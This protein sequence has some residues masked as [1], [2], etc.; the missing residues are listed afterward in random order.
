[1]TEKQW[2]LPITVEK[3]PE[4]GLPV[5]KAGRM[6][7]SEPFFYPKPSKRNPKLRLYT[8]VMYAALPTRAPHN[9]SHKDV[10]GQMKWFSE[11]IGSKFFKAWNGVMWKVWV[12][13]DWALIKKLCLGR[14]GRIEPGLLY[15]FREHEPQIRQAI[16][17]GLMHLVPLIHVTGLCPQNLRGR[18][19]KGLWRK[20]SHNTFSRNRLIATRI[21]R[22]ASR[23]GRIVLKSVLIKTGV[24]QLAVF[25]STIIPKMAPFGLE[26]Y[27]GMAPYIEHLKKAK[28]L[29]KVTV[30]QLIRSRFIQYDTRRMAQQLGVEFDENW[31][32]ATLIRKHEEFSKRINERQYS[33][34]PWSTFGWPEEVIKGDYAFHLLNN[35]YALREEGTSMHHCVGSYVEASRSGNY[36][37]YSVRYKGEKLSTLQF[38]KT[39]MGWNPGEDFAWALGQHY[40]PC[41]RILP[42]EHTKSLTPIIKD[43]MEE[44]NEKMPK[45][46]P[47]LASSLPN[48]VRRYV[49]GNPLELVW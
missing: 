11:N 19:G 4:T 25:P 23:R 33:K 3:D 22:E 5:V 35:A 7:C 32:Y 21:H 47:I 46:K 44:M 16:A 6:S 29:G 42:D 26:Q 45:P 17:D 15:N 14:F 41:N 24:E 40:G 8:D 13:D 30:D 1:M 12:G 48:P 9:I 34:E 28:L 31:G 36:I 49:E 39:T 20:L 2:P 38:R 27:S 37:H 43:M 10:K 18:F